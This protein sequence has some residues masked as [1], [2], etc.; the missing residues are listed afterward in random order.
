MNFLKR[1]QSNLL[2]FG[3]NFINSKRTPYNNFLRLQG[4]RT[5]ALK[6]N[7]TQNVGRA[8]FLPLLMTY[9]G[10]TTYKAYCIE[11]DVLKAAKN[12]IDDAIYK[13]KKEFGTQMMSFPNVTAEMKGGDKYTVEFLIDQRKCDML[14]VL[15]A[16]LGSFEKNKEGSGF[17]VLN[18][19]AYQ[20]DNITTI[21]LEFEE[22]VG[23]KK[24]H[25]IAKGT[26]YIT[27]ENTMDRPNFRLILEK[28]LDISEA[29]I[30]A[31]IAAYREANRPNNFVLQRRQFVQ[32][33]QTLPEKNVETE[34][35]ST[36]NRLEARK[37]L[38]EMGVTI[39][40]PE[41][42]QRNLDWDYLAGYEKQKRDIEDTV[43]LALSY[44]QIYDEITK[45]TRMKEEP[46]RPKAVLF[47]GPPGT[48]KTTSA[49]I[50]AQQVNIPLIYMPIESIMSKWYGE[51]EK[52]FADIFDACKV[53]GKAII[54]IDE[55]D[56]IAG[57]RDRDLHEASR[58][59]LSTLLR[60]IDSFESSTDVLLVCATNRKQ[61]L[62]SAMLSRI[63][64][65]V[66]FEMPDSQSRV[67]I[68]QRYAKQLDLKELQA[69][70]KA[71]DGLSG[72]NISDIC[73]DAERRWASKLIRKEATDKLPTVEQY[74]ESLK[75][76]KMQN[77]A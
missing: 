30:Q 13:M 31:F 5:P 72:R 36:K 43:L 76:R 24:R 26:M 77:L 74:L 62:D 29:D 10:Y 63:D 18:F 15:G 33:T 71:S 3:K 41:A 35:D 16:A 9:A 64:L 6:V 21:Q 51:A 34:E 28:S 1:S 52:R 14:S 22:Q 2:A 38:E 65:S 49:K 42:S 56:A 20:R 37:K 7:S 4:L 39:F 46:N 32:Q 48:G 60:K 8:V 69:L 67:A 66:K 59:I 70:A 53:F 61:D 68:Y 17:K 23:D 27:G 25:R 44:P 73:K 11:D 40:F 19:T 47:E 54:F 45:G 75:N 57:S 50:I 12:R 55:I 58:R